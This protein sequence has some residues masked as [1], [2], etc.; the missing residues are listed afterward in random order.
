MLNRII[1]TKF[2]MLLHE[3]VAAT[4]IGDDQCGR[5]AG[6]VFVDEIFD[7][8]KELARFITNR[9]EEADIVRLV[10]GVEVVVAAA[11]FFDA[12]AEEFEKLIVPSHMR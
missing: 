3:E 5:F 8:V 1:I 7:K 11:V 6:E 12:V 10:V 9:C 4:N 2:T